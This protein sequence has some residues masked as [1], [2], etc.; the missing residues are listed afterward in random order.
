MKPCPR[1]GAVWKLY[2]GKVGQGWALVHGKGC[3][4]LEPK[5]ETV[6]ALVD[7]EAKEGA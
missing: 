1:C 4:G 3:R 7:E 2:A 5:L 6:L